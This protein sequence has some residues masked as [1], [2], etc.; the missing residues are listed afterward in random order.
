MSVITKSVGIVATAVRWTY[1]A[2]VAVCV[3]FILFM[4]WHVTSALIAD[5]SLSDA[6]SRAT[7]AQQASRGA[8]R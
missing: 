3:V 4:G 1:H 5:G 7:A 8:P 2:A 6:A